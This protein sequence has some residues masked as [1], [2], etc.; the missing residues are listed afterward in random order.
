MAGWF[1]GTSG[2][3]IGR[4]AMQQD[5]PGCEF[6]SRDA[7]EAALNELSCPIIADVDIGHTG[8]QWT[9]VQGA[10]ACIEWADGCCSVVQ[11]LR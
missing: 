11:E 8:P 3:L 5:A 1:E 4:D 10:L 9:L 2:V 6:D 7:V